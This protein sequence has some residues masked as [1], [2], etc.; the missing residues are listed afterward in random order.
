M[1]RLVFIV[2]VLGLVS[3]LAMLAQQDSDSGGALNISATT[4]DSIKE[5][6]T[7][8]NRMVQSRELVARVIRADPILQ[9]RQHE[10]LVQHY[11]GVRVY[12]GSLSR[13]TS[14]GVTVSI[15]GT[16]LTGIALDPVP[17]LSAVQALT[18]IQ[19]VSGGTL[20]GTDSP[21]LIIFR[22]LIGTYA[23]S[24]RATMSDAKTYYVDASS[25]EVLWTVDEVKTQ[26]AVG[27]GTGVLGDRKKIA[28]RKA[29][30]AFRTHDELRPASI[31]TYDTRGSEVVNNRLLLGQAFDSDFP[32]D[33]D[34]TWTHPAVVDAHVHTGWTEDYLYKEQTWKGVDDQNSAITSIVHSGLK[35]NA[36]FLRGPY[37]PDG[38]CVRLREHRRWCPRH[39]TR[40]RGTRV[41][42][43]RH[44][45]VPQTAHWRRPWLSVLLPSAWTDERYVQRRLLCL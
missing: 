29:A 3:Q 19:N 16:L 30:G 21:E 4:H 11:Q 26:R 37:G 33:L 5:W 20:V 28:S 2:V 41:H 12:G 39:S 14:R 13:Q 9:D 8:I 27:V 10:T 38:R 40:Y 25:G 6:D 18:M 42:A 32:T 44:K 1:K 45:R 22:T 36:Y 23:L 43:R 15:L 24:Y 31:R 7:T 35:N 17:G 34:N